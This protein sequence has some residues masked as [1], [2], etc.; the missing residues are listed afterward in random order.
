MVVLA[1]CACVYTS[2]HSCLEGALLFCG[3]LGAC[4]EGGSWE[5]GR[6]GARGLGCAWLSIFIG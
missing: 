2:S 3:A 6:R 5:E 4:C 1:G